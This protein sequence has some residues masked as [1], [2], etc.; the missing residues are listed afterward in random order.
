M[1]MKLKRIPAQHV[2][3][4]YEISCRY[5]FEYCCFCDQFLKF[6]EI[7][8][9]VG[10]ICIY[11]IWY[12]KR[13]CVQKLTFISWNR[14]SL[15]LFKLTS[16]QLWKHLPV[17]VYYLLKNTANENRRHVLFPY[18]CYKNHLFW[19]VP[20]WIFVLNFLWNKCIESIDE[21]W[22]RIRIELMRAHLI[23]VNI[24]H[25]DLLNRWQWKQIELTNFLLY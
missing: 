5:D 11:C 4:I 1:Y 16:S 12:R 20:R 18:N 6:L 8:H 24:E 22:R 17:Q 21:N 7:Y 9:I 2:H 15:M 23:A 10:E 19:L 14:L 3:R 25:T 13:F